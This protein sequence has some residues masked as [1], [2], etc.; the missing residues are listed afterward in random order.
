VSTPLCPTPK[1]SF[2]FLLVAGKSLMFYSFTM[3]MVLGARR[4]L[5]HTLE[6]LAAKLKEKTHWGFATRAR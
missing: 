2:A 3:S 4:P 5:G 6:H 1:T